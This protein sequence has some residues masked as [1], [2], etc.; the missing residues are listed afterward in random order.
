MDLCHWAS[1]NRFFTVCTVKIGPV[2]IIAPTD[3]AF[4][5]MASSTLDAYIGVRDNP[6]NLIKV[7]HYHVIPQKLLPAD[8]KNEMVVQTMSN[9]KLRF[10]IYKDVSYEIEFTPTTMKE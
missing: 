6:D 2:T 4:Q 5:A 8:I 7:I 1:R 10:N 9:E 3:A